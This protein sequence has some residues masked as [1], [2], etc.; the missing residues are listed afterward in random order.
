[1]GK[2]ILTPEESKQINEGSLITHAAYTSETA[3]LCETLSKKYKIPCKAEQAQAP[4]GRLTFIFFF[5]PTSMEQAYQL[6]H[7]LSPFLPEKRDWQYL[8]DSND[9]YLVS[10]MDWHLKFKH[11]PKPISQD[12]KN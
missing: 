2:Y 3:A 6:G 1:M 9:R 7:Y 11:L 12:E 5:W 4:S 8:F 10:L